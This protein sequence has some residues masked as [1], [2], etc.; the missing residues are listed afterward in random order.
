MNET[1]IDPVLRCDSCQALLRLAVLHE[2]GSCQACGNRRVRNVQ[3]LSEE[4]RAQV[5]GW[6]LHDFLALFEARDVQA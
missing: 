4:E 5:E 6:G 3:V 2:V 1:S